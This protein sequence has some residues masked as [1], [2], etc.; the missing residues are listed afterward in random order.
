[1]RQRL[2][3][4]PSPWGQRRGKAVKEGSTG[5]GGEERCS[6]VAC[7][8]CHGAKHIARAFEQPLQGNVSHF[9]WWGR[10]ARELG[11]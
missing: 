11:E 1:M 9:H 10:R 7:N 3:G 4:S 5:G 6:R 8:D 2:W